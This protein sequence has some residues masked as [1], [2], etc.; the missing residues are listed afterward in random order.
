MLVSSI[1]IAGALLS[2]YGCTNNPQ[3]ED[4][5]AHGT[6][7]E[8]SASG[9]QEEHTVTLT[10]E[11]V[12]TVGIEIGSVEQKQLSAAMKAN[13]FLRVPNNNKA[14]VTSLFGGIIKT[15]P[16]EVG[17]YVKKGQTIATISNPQFIQLQEEYLSISNKIAFPNKN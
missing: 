15:L 4:G 8:T 9:H 1:C 10:D 16:V 14:H 13:G 17:N 11:Q 6:P 3:K 5:H 7:P 12:K 2:F